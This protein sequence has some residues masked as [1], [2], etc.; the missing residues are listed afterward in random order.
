MENFTRTAYGSNL[1]ASQLL[2]IPVKILPNTTLNEK[3][4]IQSGIAIS[5][6]DVPKMR[7]AAIGNGGHRLTV[8]ASGIPLPEPLQ[9]SPTD[10][11][12]FNHIP[13]VLRE[14]TNDLSAQDRLKYA[15]RRI[16][17]HDTTT[18]V[19][20]YLKRLDYT[21]VVT[22]LNYK[23]VT[24]GVTTTTPF[25]PTSTNL[26]PTP[27]ATS[28][29]GA[30]LTTGDYVTSSAKIPFSLSEADVTEL[31]NVAVIIYG[32]AAYAIISEVALVS[33][34][35]KLIT[36]S[37]SNNG[38]FSFNEVIGAQVVSFMEGFYA[39]NFT[40]TG[41][42]LVLEVGATESLYVLTPG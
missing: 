39:L 3:F 42:D 27:A 18:Y 37:S 8:G 25:L 35:D 40:N 14:L 23:S 41:L 33:G 31:I 32:L 6:T 34:V 28:P 11:A 13:F 5:T 9:H 26:S 10:A 36:A 22:A 20:Y 1:Q 16:E 2:G 12:L 15:L 7:Y 29:V 24:N 4:N 38:S 21:D 17:T 30:N 19:A